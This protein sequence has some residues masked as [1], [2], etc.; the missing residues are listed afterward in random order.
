MQTNQKLH[1][2]LILQDYHELCCQFLTHALGSPCYVLRMMDLD[3]CFTEYVRWKKILGHLMSEERKKL[4]RKKYKKAE[5]ATFI[6]RR[7][8]FRQAA[9]CM[10]VKDVPGGMSDFLP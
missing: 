9:L 7:T 3:K 4:K 6:S 2:V 8:Y 10:Y 1:V 5:M